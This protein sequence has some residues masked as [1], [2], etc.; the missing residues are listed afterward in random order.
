VLLSSLPGCAPHKV[1]IEGVAHE[2]STIPGVAE[3]VVEIILNLKSL[4]FKLFEGDEAS[5]KLDVSGPKEVKGKDFKLPSNLELLNPEQPIATL[6]RGAKLKLDLTINRG[7]GYVPVERKEEER[8]E[9]G[10]ILLDS[11]YTPVTKVRYDIENTRVGKMTNYD[12]LILEI[13]TDGTMTPDEA[14]E[15]SGQILERH[16]NLV[17][18]ARVEIEKGEKKEQEIKAKIKTADIRK[19]KISDSDLPNRAKKV[20]SEAGI[21]T[22]GGLL[23]LSQEKLSQIKGMG[24]KTR[25]E[26]EKQIKKWGLKK[27]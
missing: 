23:N 9:I 13:I 2:F 4:R 14:L 5:A 18:N 17:S 16:F 20:L 11:L 8:R 15:A 22:V 3:D 12:R 7:I 25:K 24:A 6:S 26:I 19:M 27:E 10:V 1:K 21:K